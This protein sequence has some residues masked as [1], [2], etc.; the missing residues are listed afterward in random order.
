[1]QSY[2][3]M[4]RKEW[5]RKIKKA[6]LEKSVVWL[7][8]VR[9]SGKTT[10]CKTLTPDGY[11]DCELPRIRKL[12]D[13]PED[14][15]KKL[16]KKYITLDEIH[17]LDH[18]SEVLK[19]A[20]DHFP[21]I[22]IVATGSSTLGAS[23]KFKDTLTDRKR[24]VFLTPMGL[25]DL[26]DFK[27]TNLSHRLS[28]GGLPPFF[29]SPEFPEKGY[30]EWLDS[31]W[32]KDIEELFNIEKKYAFLKFFELLA[33]QS[34]GIFEAKSFAAPCGVSHTTIASY[35]NVMEQTH[36]A[37]VLRPFHK[38]QAKEIITA[39]KVYFFDTGFVNYF[40]GVSEMQKEDKG[41]FWEH[42]VLNELLTFIDRENIH[43]WRDKSKNEVDIVI[44]FRGRPPIA[45]DCKWQEKEFRI[46][47]VAKFREIHKEGISLLLASDIK[48]LQRK[49]Y[50]EHTIIHCPLKKIKELIMSVKKMNTISKI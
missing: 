48:I 8:G 22:K 40:K 50:G 5:C 21:Q 13:D 36:I 43:Y 39:P 2:L 42:F 7:T 16:T 12:L 45:I 9:R 27:K 14:F 1:M 37:Y 30:Q 26:Q 11:F 28:R 18:A 17:R 32:A 15:F 35:L 6:W 38:N 10:I 34:G 23:K 33:L 19:I 20:A 29:L 25:A 3:H 31:F 46:N 24:V 4:V 49:S 44:K 47:S 41:H